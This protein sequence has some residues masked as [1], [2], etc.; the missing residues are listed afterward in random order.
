MSERTPIDDSRLR[1]MKRL[2]DPLADELA[3]DYLEGDSVAKFHA[4]IKAK[5]SSPEMLDPKVAEFLIEHPPLPDWA[6]PARLKNG[7]EFFALW[8]VQLGLGLFLQALP[9]AY[10]S[11]EGVQVLA[12]TSKLET[13]AN[14][15]V[16][17]SAQFVLDVT[18]PRAL[19]PG[20]VGYETSRHVRL[21]HAGVRYLI[22]HDQ[23]ITRTA[24]TEVWP[25]WDPEWGTPINQQHLLGA[26][27][28]YSSSLLEV[29][30]VLGADYDEIGAAD[31]CL[32][33]NAVGWLLGVDETVLPLERHEMTRLQDAI[34]RSNE[35]ESEAG[36]TMTAALLQLV[37]GYVKFPGFKGWPATLMRVFIGDTTADYLGVPKPDWTRMLVRATRHLG[38]NPGGRH[39]V[40]RKAVTW[41]SSRVLR[42]FVEHERGDDRPTFSIPTHLDLKVAKRRRKILRARSRSRS[43]R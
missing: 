19:E 33:W 42:G 2:G 34:R 41:A 43:G 21:M 16:L 5:Y 38:H 26:M 37:Q 22:D 8:G 31:Y 30:D 18:S 32:L 25:R 24:D 3:A 12:L 27:L 10:A 35:G 14:R 40:M 15:R 17:E 6:T 1:A 4:A 36:R 29:L 7:A 13:E 11:V 28:S 20:K 39:R 23:R 9:L